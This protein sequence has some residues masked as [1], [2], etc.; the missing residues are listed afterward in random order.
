MV[1]KNNMKEISYSKP[2][3]PLPAVWN[4][5]KN[6]NPD[7][8]LGCLKMYINN[9]IML[10]QKDLGKEKT[11]STKDVSS[12]FDRQQ[13]KDA[14]D[15]VVEL[16]KLWGG[17]FI[18]TS[19]SSIKEDAEFLKKEF[20]TWIKFAV[21]KVCNRELYFSEWKRT[22]FCI[23][24]KSICGK[25][26]KIKVRDYIFNKILTPFWKSKIDST[27][28]PLD[29]Y[30][31]HDCFKALSLI[32]VKY[33]KIIK[34][35]YWIGNIHREKNNLRL[36]QSEYFKHFLRLI[37]RPLTLEIEKQKVEW[38]INQLSSDEVRIAERLKK[39]DYVHK[40]DRE[41]Q[42]RGK[43]SF[44]D[45]S[46]KVRKNIK[47]AWAYDLHIHT[48]TSDGAEYAAD[49]FV[50]MSIKNLDSVAILDHQRVGVN[51]LKAYIK[52]CREEWGRLLVGQEVEF[53]GGYKSG[54]ELSGIFFNLNE[55]ELGKKTEHELRQFAKE[56]S[57][58]SNPLPTLEELADKLISLGATLLIT[59]PYG[60]DY[61]FLQDDEGRLKRL[62][63][64]LYDKGKN[65]EECLI[66]E[67][68]NAKNGF[69]EDNRDH[70]NSKAR[71][72]ANHFPD[73]VK[74][75]IL[76]FPISAGSDSHLGLFDVGTGYCIIR[77][78]TNQNI[79]E[80]IENL[81]KALICPP[82]KYWFNEG[83]FRK[84]FE[85][86]FKNLK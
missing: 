63:D 15:D 1:V 12:I 68:F 27:N 82:K 72:K 36:A 42:L 65:P 28:K 80:C 41:L 13:I 33:Q 52:S 16:A 58:G 67:V 6:K 66:I 37:W 10:W 5:M 79:N 7:I 4:F 59:H 60:R 34:E 56:L 81:R 46:E 74:K 20:D 8:A 23:W 47:E 30:E 25:T 19:K 78:P 11:A 73:D 61:S 35:H 45:I 22:F 69:D 21:K 48:K 53:D 43:K 55:E 49:V 62:M 64:H 32:D 26:A 71:K 84:G 18:A 9:E 24:G 54:V 51:A 86:I 29:G 3:N 85:Y 57:C 38:A 39:Y 83:E 77:K 50:H 76:N 14:K 2:Y 44:K 40:I 75:G 70:P 31:E 17:F